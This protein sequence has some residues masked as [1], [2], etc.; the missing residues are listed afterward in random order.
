MM[1]SDIEYVVGSNPYEHL[2][3][4]ELKDVLGRLDVEV[5]IL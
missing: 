3:L 2:T 5:D 1:E 4:Q